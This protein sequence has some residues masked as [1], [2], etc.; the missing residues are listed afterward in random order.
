MRW[1]LR[2]AQLAL[3]TDVPVGALLCNGQGQPIGWG[4]NTRETCHDPLGHAE[5][6]A[7]KR[8]SERLGQ[9]RM[10]HCT[11]YVTLEPCPMCAAALAQS[12]LSRLVYG[13]A[14]PLYGAAGSRWQLLQWPAS[15]CVV[16]GVAEAQC[17]QQLEAFFHTLRHHRP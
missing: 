3:P 1:A 10:S 12:R 17:R 2:L 16:G 6:T 4:W 5:L 9:W 13:T 7:L 15:V 8:A 11:L 14:D